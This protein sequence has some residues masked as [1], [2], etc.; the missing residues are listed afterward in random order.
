MKVN[1][2]A[3]FREEFDGTAL[4]FNPGNNKI[5]NLNSSAVVIWKCLTRNMDDREII[6][7]LQEK[8][9]MTLVSSTS[10]VEGG[11][12]DVT[13]RDKEATNR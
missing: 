5:L 1:P 9:K 13:L 8:A 12:H 2:F 10:I 7:E 11:Y 3:V 4:L 6:E